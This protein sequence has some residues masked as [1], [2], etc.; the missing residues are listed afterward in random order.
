M[1]WTDHSPLA[2]TPTL[3]HVAI[4]VRDLDAAQQN[5]AR[6]GFIAEGRAFIP[7]QSVE[8]V[9]MQ[10]GEGWV[11]LLCPTDP[12]GPISRFLSSRGEGL[13]H[14]AY[15]VTALESWLRQLEEAG[16]RLIDRVP[17]EGAHGWQIAFIHPESC[18][19]VL[20]ELVQ[21]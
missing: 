18:S 1:H 3:H 15:R 6:L 17:R 16:I 9:T 14:V 19:G 11:E 8:V 20:T 21:E 2:D 13:H 5:Y 4:V 7:S 10:A 12:E